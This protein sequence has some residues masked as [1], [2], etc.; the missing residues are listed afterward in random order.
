MIKFKNSINSRGFILPTAMMLGAIG[1]IL[2]LVPFT[3]LVNREIRLDHRIAKTK[4]RLNAESGLANVYSY[5]SLDS[6]GLDSMSLAGEFFSIDYTTFKNPVQIPNGM[7]F[8]KDIILQESLNDLSRRTERNAFAVGESN[9][10]SFG[11]NISVLDTMVMSFELESLSE[12]L[13]LTNHE[14]AGGAPG[15]YGTQGSN[16]SGGT[17]TELTWRGKPCFGPDDG[18]GNDINVAG[19]VQ[20]NDPML[21]CS[22]VG[23]TELFPNTVYITTADLDY[24]SSPF[25]TLSYEAGES[26]KP[27]GG[28]FNQN[29]GGESGPP[30][31]PNYIE[32]EKVCFPMKGYF[33][34]VNAATITVDAT[35]LLNRSSNVTSGER[36]KLIMTDIEFLSTGGFRIKRYWYLLPPYQKAIAGDNNLDGVM[37]DPGARLLQV[38]LNLEGVSDATDQCRVNNIPSGTVDQSSCDQYQV[39][40]EDF[41]G[42]VVTNPSGAFFGSNYSERYMLTYNN[43]SGYT[44]NS[45]N[46]GYPPSYGPNDSDPSTIEYPN[47][48]GHTN[49][50]HYDPNNFWRYY[51]NQNNNWENASMIFGPFTTPGDPYNGT[52]ISDDSYQN[53][54]AVIHIKGGPVTVHGS[55]NGRY[56]VVTSGFDATGGNESA[57]AQ[58]WAT[59]YRDAWNSGFAGGTNQNNILTS[60]WQGFPVDT[61]FSNIWIT[62]DLVNVD[63]GGGNNGPPQP[64]IDEDGDGNN[65]CAFITPGSCGGTSNIMGLVSSANVIIANSPDNRNASNQFS[66]GVNVHA[67]IVALNES[68]VMQYWQHNLNDFGNQWDVSPLTDNRGQN[69][70]GASNTDD[71]RGLLRLW[72]GIIQSY[73]GYMKRSATGPYNGGNIGMDKDYFFDQNL[74]FPPPNFPYISRCPDE[75]ASTAAMTMIS[76]QP[77]T[78]EV[79]TIYESVD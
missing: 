7:G 42:K 15:I 43:A 73:R 2:T 9:I 45:Y 39:P 54:E 72:G 65:D 13:Y 1:M 34:T 46:R 70:Y 6:L 38:P 69:I 31:H 59:Y 66:V 17:G 63:A 8:Y 30:I 41:H 4:A 53:E 62:G 64:V 77:V 12:Y 33:S 75:G 50:S 21:M 27:D 47:G 58:G 24:E 44:N 52:L 37:D 55:F 11:K 48:Y 10:T 60:S 49:L 67:S 20:T 32:K 14:H 22:T 35:E 36:D 74:S 23:T 19:F 25:N 56:T 79:K 78:T 57:R 76:Y 3:N 28:S 51:T 26:I 71:H 29:F 40:M 61:V 68:F 18:V 5:F 16:E